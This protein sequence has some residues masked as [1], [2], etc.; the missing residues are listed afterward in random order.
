MNT[1][2]IYVCCGGLCIIRLTGRK[3][4]VGWQHPDDLLP[5][6]L[7][8]GLLSAMVF[9]WQS[10]TYYK[11]PKNYHFRY[12]LSLIIWAPPCHAPALK[13][14]D[15]VAAPVLALQPHFPSP[16]RKR[17]ECVAEA[18]ISQDRLFRNA[19]K[20]PIARPAENTPAHAE[21][22]GE[23]WFIKVCSV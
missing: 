10:Q 22:C 11:S 17:A 23:R 5:I 6:S 18:L 16:E 21:S 12:F 1:V 2:C 8:L 14:T 13:N 9:F 4:T 7:P 19:S 3:H 15:I 20:C